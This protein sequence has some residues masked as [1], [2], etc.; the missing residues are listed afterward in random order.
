MVAT[1][2]SNPNSIVVGGHV[3]AFGADGSTLFS[4]GSARIVASPAALQALTSA[5]DGQEFDV[6]SN[7]QH[8][9][10]ASA[11]TLTTDAASALV[12]TATGIGSGAFIRT[13]TDVDLKIAIDKTIAD[14]TAIFTVPA[15][16]RLQL[17]LAWWEVTTS[18]T[19]GSSSAIGLSS[20]SS[21]MSTKGDVLG[22]AS[23]DVL[24]TLV[25]TGALAKGTVGAKYGNPASI[26][27]GADTI[28]FDRITSAFT[29]GAGFAHVP[30][31]VLLA[32][33]S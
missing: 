21:A 31:K 1:Q 30:V 29:A 2:L 32:P 5:L 9:R 18:W 17:G 24:A 23:G 7:G 19:G 3:M 12:L 14:A 15:G 8:W 22:G 25:S 10:Y 4:S 6:Q 28:R 33:A 20:S 27:V 26:F 13:D 16:F 11:S